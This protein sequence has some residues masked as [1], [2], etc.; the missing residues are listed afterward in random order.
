MS[1]VIG[2]AVLSA[3]SWGDFMERIL[4]SNSRRVCAVHAAEIEDFRDVSGALE[5][6]HGTLGRLT[7]GPPVA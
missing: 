6:Y 4:G 3:I 7:P 2:A 5:K 1:V